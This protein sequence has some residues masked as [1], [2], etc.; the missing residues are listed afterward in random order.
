MGERTAGDKSTFWSKRRI[1]ERYPIA[2]SEC[3][4]LSDGE[5]RTIFK[6]ILSSD[7]FKE[8]ESFVRD[9]L[10]SQEGA[11]TQEHLIALRAYLFELF[12]YELVKRRVNWIDLQEGLGVDIGLR[13]LSPAETFE[14]MRIV[15]PE[16]RVTACHMGLAR[17]I[18]VVNNPDGIL[19][20]VRQDKTTIAG[21]FEYT[22]HPSVSPTSS[23]SKEA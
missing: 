5:P 10:L 12:A 20:G 17:C 2:L 13:V 21:F 19:L 6:K 9:I 18:D 14:L 23:G 3:S 7:E 11:F 8:A 1:S 4:E 16:G 22:L 15:Y